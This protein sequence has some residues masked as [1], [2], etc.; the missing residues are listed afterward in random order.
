MAEL[1]KK[2]KA[3]ENAQ[4]AEYRALVAEYEGYKIDINKEREGV[5]QCKTSMERD[6]KHRRD[7]MWFEELL[8]YVDQEADKKRMRKRRKTHG[9]YARGDEPYTSYFR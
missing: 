4:K 9:V 1:E 3:E 8:A 5:L 7:S 2:H 6:L